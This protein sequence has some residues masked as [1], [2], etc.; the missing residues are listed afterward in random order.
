M[1][2]ENILIIGDDL[3]AQSTIDQPLPVPK[4]Q[5]MAGDGSWLSGRTNA[6]AENSCRNIT[7]NFRITSSASV[8]KPPATG[9]SAPSRRSLRHAGNGW[10]TCKGTSPN[11]RPWTWARKF[12]SI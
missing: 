5:P 4:A 2:E 11:I 12:S 10:R 1:N 7:P 3:A 9:D 6:L 8:K